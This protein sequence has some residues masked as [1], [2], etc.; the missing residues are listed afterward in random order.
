MNFIAGDYVLTIRPEH[1][2]GAIKS[3]ESNPVAKAFREIL[4]TGHIGSDREQ[5]VAAWY[6]NGDMIS[7]ACYH[8]AELMT[9]LENW[10]TGQPVGFASFP[11]KIIRNE[12]M[13]GYERRLKERISK[14][15][16]MIADL[17]EREHRHWHI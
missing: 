4:P 7:V 3:W 13:E 16:A 2:A 17:A 11:V 12:W 9:W 5:T 14:I 1:I 10:E 6:H 15:H 8:P